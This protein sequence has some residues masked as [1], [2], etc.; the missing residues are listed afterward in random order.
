MK[1]GANGWSERT[2][3]EPRTEAHHQIVTEEVQ[4]QVA[5][6]ERLSRRFFNLTHGLVK[7]LE[8][9]EEEQASTNSALSRRHG[10]HIQSPK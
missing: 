9:G 1:E 5:V 8:G 4:D 2:R 7:R 10:K 6:F 3:P